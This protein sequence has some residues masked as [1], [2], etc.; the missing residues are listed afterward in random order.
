ISSSEVKAPTNGCLHPGSRGVSFSCD[1][2]GVDCT[3]V[4]YHSL[5]NNNYELCRPC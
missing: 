5:K 2:C 3:P 4:P 1:T